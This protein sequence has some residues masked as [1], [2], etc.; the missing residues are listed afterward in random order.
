MST[1][2]KALIQ[3]RLRAKMVR[4]GPDYDLDDE[5]A[6]DSDRL[7]RQPVEV[8]AYD[9]S[10]CGDDE[11][12]L[13]SSSSRGPITRR[14]NPTQP[15]YPVRL[16]THI[17]PSAYLVPSQQD[18]RYYPPSTSYGPGSSSHGDRNR[19]RY[20]RYPREQCRELDAYGLPPRPEQQQH[21]HTRRRHHSHQ[22]VREQQ[23]PHYEPPSRGGYVSKHPS[24]NRA[25]S[26]WHRSEYT[27]APSKSSSMS[28]SPIR[29]APSPT[30]SSASRGYRKQDFD[31]NA[32]YMRHS[33]E[34][35]SILPSPRLTTPS[36]SP[37]QMHRRD[38]FQRQRYTWKDRDHDYDNQAA[39]EVREPSPTRH[40]D[41]LDY[42]VLDDPAR[43]P[44]EHRSHSNQTGNDNT[45]NYSVA[46]LPSPHK[47]EPEEI[48]VTQSVHE[49]ER[50]S[51]PALDMEIIEPPAKTTGRTRAWDDIMSPESRLAANAFVEKR[52]RRT[53]KSTPRT[54]ATQRWLAVIDARARK[55]EAVN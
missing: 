4:Q 13:V 35:K 30:H 43:R 53:Q 51:P 5:Y 37:H 52:Q 27:A 6:C 36:S 2:L 38:D 55:H 45:R 17:D 50:H 28:R 20:S 12:V 47:T 9:I 18:D 33:R 19:Q 49:P 25:V 32:D 29:A 31:Y 3:E 34:S 42:P 48:Y 21:S 15:T 39:Y 44:Y 26:P 22:R 8:T 54:M 46:A 1:P 23:Q 10:S 16:H 11:D 14:S 7:L 41:H 40:A 24:Q